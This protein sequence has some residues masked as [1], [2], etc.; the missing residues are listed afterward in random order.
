L[1]GDND[2]RVLVLDKGWEGERFELQKAIF[3]AIIK[4]S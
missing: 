1:S 3:T 4:L 2:R